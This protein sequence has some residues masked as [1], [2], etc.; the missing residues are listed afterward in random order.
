MAA[1]AAA[2]WWAN[3]VFSPWADSMAPRLWLYDTL[4]Y[5]GFALLAWGLVEAA[6]VFVRWR[7]SRKV[8]AFAWMATM[9]V[10]VALAVVYARTEAGLRFKVR[11][12]AAA[13]DRS[14]T[15]PYETPRHRAGHFLVDTV[16]EPVKGEPWL[17]IGQPFGGGTGT[18][19]ALVRSGRDAP[20]PPEDGR[21]RYR[22][23][24]GGWW[25]AEVE[26]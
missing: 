4:Y 1:L 3:S 6:L 16:R 11:T 23:I 17:W 19:R 21:Y 26:R 12:S 22:A 13:L 10:G 20:T 8:G 9:L 7:A 5:L 14:A 24:A 25:M 15:L 18:G 2:W